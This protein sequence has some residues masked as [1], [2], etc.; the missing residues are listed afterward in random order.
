[1]EKPGGLAG[2]LFCWDEIRPSG[3]AVF[4]KVRN[5]GG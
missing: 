2:L 4:V 3:V 5:T 1:M